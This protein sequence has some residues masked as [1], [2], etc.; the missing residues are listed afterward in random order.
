[1]KKLAKR[2]IQERNRMYKKPHISAHFSAKQSR[3]LD[4]YSTRPWEVA[5]AARVAGCHRCSVYRWMDCPAFA[6]VMRASE[7]AENL[8]RRAQSDAWLREMRA[9]W[10]AETEARADE[11]ILRIRK[12]LRRRR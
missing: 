1:M 3:F 4:A 12:Q 7:D 2:P 10:R 5:E 6:Q 11:L 8:R 9:K